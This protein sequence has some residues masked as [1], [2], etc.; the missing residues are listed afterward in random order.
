MVKRKL[1]FVESC[2]G[3]AGVGDAHL[4]VCLVDRVVE[5]REVVGF[6]DFKGDAFEVF[7]DGL[8]RGKREELLADVEVEAF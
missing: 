6:G 3:V 2:F 7:G 1:Y 8:A 5:R 4:A